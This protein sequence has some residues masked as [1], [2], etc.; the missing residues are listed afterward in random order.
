MHTMDELN[1][2]GNSLKGSR[3]LLSFDA[4]FDAT[5]HHALMKELLTQIFGTPKG[6]PKSKPFIDHVISFSLIDNKIWFRNFQILEEPV[7]G[8]KKTETTLVEIGPRFVMNPVKILSGSFS[9]A[10]LW[11]NPNY[12]TP[13]TLRAFEKHKEATKYIE[14]LRGNKKYE[15]KLEQNVIPTD[16]LA[17]VFDDNGSFELEEG[18]E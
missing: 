13:N 12:F 10:T 6:H 1:F 9:G 11:D 8:T 16:E 17:D 15:T 5:P 14:R 7:E 2:T 4:G 18:D 3:P